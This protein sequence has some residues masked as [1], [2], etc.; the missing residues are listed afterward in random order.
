MELID[1]SE[2]LCSFEKSKVSCSI[3]L[4]DDLFKET[5]LKFANS[6]RKC[7]FVQIVGHGVSERVISSAMRESALFFN[8]PGELKEACISKDKA[9]RGYSPSLSENFASLIG[10]SGKPNDMVQKYR[11]GPVIDA[12][13]ASSN[14]PY[15]TTKD[16]RIHFYPNNETELAEHFPTTSTEY[17]K[18]MEQLAIK[19]LRL[20]LYCSGAPISGF[21]NIMD[22]HTSILS[23]NYYEPVNMNLE[24]TAEPQVRVELHTD[25]SLLTIV[26]QSAEQDT[27]AGALQIFVP[28]DNSEG[29]EFITVPYVPG[30]LVVNIGDCLQDWSQERFPSALHRVI[31]LP[32]RSEDKSKI[33]ESRNDG[34]RYSL[35]YFC[36]PNY[37]SLMVWPPDSTAAPTIAE[38]MDMG[39]ALPAS[40]S[41]IMDY[42]TWRKQ[43]I[44]KSMQQLKKN[45]TKPL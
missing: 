3:C 2:V 22:K 11:I 20:I 17:Y 6:L 38:A 32:R 8:K 31:N 5:A 45:A 7:G 25:V 43:H 16:G 24:Q 29:G 39:G 23:L 12:T 19:L 28:G 40:A 42:S 37:D 27:A 13:S 18:E 44:K 30:S 4:R 9:R 26:A 21:D 41:P 14:T 33:G 34:S 10:T 36:A 1:L 15:Y 35:A